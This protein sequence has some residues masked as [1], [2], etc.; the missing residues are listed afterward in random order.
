MPALR[1]PVTLGLSGH[2]GR[3]LEL[4]PY[5]RRGASVPSPLG[6]VPLSRR[7][8]SS[9]VLRTMSSITTPLQPVRPRPEQGRVIERHEIAALESSLLG[10]G[11]ALG[12]RCVMLFEIEAEPDPHRRQ[13]CGLSAGLGREGVHEDVKPVPPLCDREGTHVRSSRSLASNRSLQLMPGMS[14]V[15]CVE[16]PFLSWCLVL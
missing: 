1:R 7:T 14:S 3:Q 4:I 2:V 13:R 6:H 11:P 15:F 9:L 16:G 5:A 10:L 12:W 8:C